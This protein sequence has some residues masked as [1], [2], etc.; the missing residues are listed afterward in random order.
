MSGCTSHEQIARATSPNGRLDALV[1]ESD[2]GA[3]CDVVDEVWVVPR[4]CRRGDRVALFDDAIRSER[5]W[6]VTVRW[7]SA[8]HLVIEYLR[9][10]QASLLMRKTVIAGQDVQVSMRGGISDPLAP[11]GEMPK[12]LPRQNIVLST[13]R[14]LPEGVLKGLAG[15]AKD[16]C[17]DQFVE[18]F[19]K[20]CATKF[21]VHLRWRELPITPSGETAVLVEND[22]LGFCGSGGCALYLLARRKDTKFTQVLGSNGGLGTLDRVS[23]MK[24]TTKG[25]YNIEVM[26]SDRIT[27]SVYQW[28]GSQYSE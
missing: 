27:R 4:G 6:G 15:E 22:N 10:D 19:R 14:T 26:W 9:A 12:N 25:Y 24:K 11:A 13:G 1:L 21:A 8:D 23:V 2:C 7:D 18:G 3:V 16:Y 20:G 28:D 17:E 5:A